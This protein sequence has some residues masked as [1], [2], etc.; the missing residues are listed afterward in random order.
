[1]PDLDLIKQG[2]QGVRTG[3]GGSRGADLA[4]PPAGRAAAATPSPLNYSP[5]GILMKDRGSR[6]AG[7][8]AASSFSRSRPSL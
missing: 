5:R 4:I 3:A 7:G 6:I 2:E 1:M 8:A